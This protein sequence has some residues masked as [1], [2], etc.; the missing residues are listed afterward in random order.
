LQPLMLVERRE[1][2]TELILEV[3]EIG[4]RAVGEVGG[5]K[6]KPLRRIPAPPEKIKDNQVANKK[7]VRR[8]FKHRSDVD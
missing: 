7:T 8:A 5:F 2:E 3:V 1:Q 4:D 6:D